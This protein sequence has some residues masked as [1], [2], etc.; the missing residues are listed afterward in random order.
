M[1]FGTLLRQAR[2]AAGFTQRQL[3]NAADVDFSYISKLENDHMPPPAA[4]TI[5]RLCRAM[6]VSPESLLAATGKLPSDVHQSVGVNEAAQEFLRE[7]HR[8]KLTNNEWRHLHE[9]VRKLRSRTR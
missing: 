2:R 1:T 4:D 8:L 7:A 3:A 5:V 6:K 9:H